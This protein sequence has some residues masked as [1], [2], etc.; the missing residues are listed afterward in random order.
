MRTSVRRMARLSGLVS[1]ALVV[2]IGAGLGSVDAQRRNKRNKGDAARLDNRRG[3]DYGYDYS[4]GDRNNKVDL[5]YQGLVNGYTA[6]FTV[7]QRH[8]RD[9]Q[10]FNYRDDGGYRGGTQGWNN[11]WGQGRESDYRTYF[12]QG[13][14]QG[15]SDGFYARA[16][17]RSYAQS[18]RGSQVYD[19]RSGQYDP[20]YGYS[21][22]SNSETYAGYYSNE[23]GDLEPRE[24]GE[25]G[26]QNGYYAGY[27]RGLYDAQR[28]NRANPQGHGAYQFALDGFDPEWGSAST[29]RS[30][31]REYFVRGYEDAFGRR[32]F[33]QTYRRRY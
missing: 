26:A 10:S 23:R 31:Y 4:A 16:R 13:F 3:E 8:R 24:V 29:Y 20:Y 33:N 2:V 32:N 7:G 19:Y 28:R 17:N 6:G 25:R 14:I 21:S 27:Q 15:Y 18:R 5:R 1:L 12:R 22:Y 30:S 11:G 9:R